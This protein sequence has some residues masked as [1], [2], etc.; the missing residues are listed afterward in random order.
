MRILVCVKQVPASDSQVTIRGSSIQIN[1]K[2]LRP[3]AMNRFDEYAVEAA[4]SIEEKMPDT[5]VDVISVGP[6]RVVETIKRALGMGAGNGIHILT[7]ESGM[8]DP[9]QTAALTA[10]VAAGR[11]YDLILAGLMSEDDGHCMTGPALAEMLGIPYITYAVGIE[12]REDE[13]SVE[14]ELSGNTREV[15]RAK[16]PALLTV[17]AGINHPRYPSLTNMMRAEKNGLET[18]RAADVVAE[19]ASGNVKVIGYEY[20]ARKRN[21]VFLEGPAAEKAAQLGKIL[22]EKHFVVMSET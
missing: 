6:P 8:L 2:G 1:E 17:Q 16:L 3:Y 13:V 12:I 9:A 7:D 5:I 18:I 22:I 11:N 10:G 15:V 20:P 14:R 19:P 4:V 21:A